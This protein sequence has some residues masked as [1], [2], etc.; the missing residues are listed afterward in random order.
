MVLP[1]YQNKHQSSASFPSILKGQA[2]CQFTH[3]LLQ[4]ESEDTEPRSAVEI[5]VASLSLTEIKGRSIKVVPGWEKI[6]PAHA[7]MDGG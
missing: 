1:L 4:Q 6:A 3:F 2:V 7:W 5:R